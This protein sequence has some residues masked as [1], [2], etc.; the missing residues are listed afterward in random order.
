MLVRPGDSFPCDG[1]VIQGNS[2]VDESL[3]AT[4]LRARKGAQSVLPFRYVAA[5][6]AAR[7]ADLARGQTTVGPHRDDIA[8]T[9]AGRPGRSFASQGQQRTAALALHFDAH[10]ALASH[11]VR[12]DGST[13]DLQTLVHRATGQQARPIVAVAG[14]AQPRAG[15]GQE[16]SRRGQSSQRGVSGQYEP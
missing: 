13:L 6:R 4:A 3:I 7:A 15:S 5:L 14:T 8:L 10:R 12:M 9:I 16:P 2:G 11:A 1:I